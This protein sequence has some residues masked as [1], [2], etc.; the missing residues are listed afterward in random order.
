MRRSCVVAAASL[1]GTMLTGCMLIPYPH[2]HAHAGF[3]DAS[4]ENLGEKVPEFIVPGQTTRQVVL[5]QL[6]DP[7]GAARDESWFAYGSALREKGVGI[8]LLAVTGGGGAATNR[9]RVQYRR[10]LVRFDTAGVV[11]AVEIQEKECPRW[12]GVLDS[13]EN[14]YSHRCLEMSGASPANSEAPSA[15]MPVEFAMARRL[16]PA[17]ENV[18]AV[19]TDAQWYPDVAVTYWDTLMHDHVQRDTIVISDR[20]LVFKRYGPRS[21]PRLQR[22][23]YADIA[24]VDFKSVA[25]V[26]FVVITQTTGRVD[27]FAIAQSQTQAAADLLRANVRAVRH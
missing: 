27:S 3:D 11:T 19:F 12:Y 23:P 24:S 22:I 16:I 9:E 21:D 2:I 15:P 7:D 10:L 1:M 25:G 17:D 26:R 6:G 14:L 8:G 20:S 5:L 4:R 18:E 13:G